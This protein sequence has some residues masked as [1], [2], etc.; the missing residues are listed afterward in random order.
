M[1]SVSEILRRITFCTVKKKK[2]HAPQLEEEVVKNITKLATSA[3]D[4]NYF[5]SNR[6]RTVGEHLDLL[7][8]K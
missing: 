8:G 7:T 4:K 3:V 6:L 5:G 1:L 2:N